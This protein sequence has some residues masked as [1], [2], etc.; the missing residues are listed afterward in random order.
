MEILP[1]IRIVDLGLYLEKHKTLVFSDF[2]MGYEDTMIGVG[3]LVPKFAL[4]DTMHRLG[5]IFST[6]KGCEAV[7]LNGDLKHEFG[8]ISRQEWKDTL[9]LLDY[10][11]TKVSRVY[12]VKGNH[13]KALAPIV[14]KR[15][16]EIVPSVLLGD[17]LILHGDV[18]PKALAPGVKTIVI[19]HVH[20][21][22]RLR[23]G[24]RNE[25]FKCYLLGKYEKR[26][27]IV[28]PSFHQLHEGQ[29][30]LAENFSNPYFADFSKWKVWIVADKVY[31]FGRVRDFVK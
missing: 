30:I 22:V 3:A 24:Y 7:I 17:I 2:H 21:A 5:R 19:G 12:I 29:D 8:R 13:D 18:T 31:E 9:K 25:T 26:N 23:E 10:L 11:L 28:Q 14:G 4:K 20:P 15:G 16:I 1:G 27:L 6:L